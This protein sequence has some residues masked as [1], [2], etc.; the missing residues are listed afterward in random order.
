[1]S[2]TGHSLLISLTA[3]SPPMNPVVS[4]IRY[5]DGKAA[6]WAWAPGPWVLM[7]GVTSTLDKGL[8]P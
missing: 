8:H 6:S 5:G 7:L 1:M 4:A 3:E 2:V